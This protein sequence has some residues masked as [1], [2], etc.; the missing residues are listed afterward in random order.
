MK[1]VSKNNIPKRSRK[2]LF[3]PVL[4]LLFFLVNV[5]ASF[6]VVNS[7]FDKANEFYKEKDFQHAILLYKKL[8]SSGTESPEVYFNLGN[9]YFKCDSNAL[10]ILNYE[11]AKKLAPG[12]EDI[13]FNLNIAN[14]RNS[15]KFESA[16]ELF[17]NSWWAE[18]K[19]SKTMDGWAWLCIS[20]WLLSFLLLATFISFKASTTKRLGFWGGLFFLILAVFSFFLAEDQSNASSKKADAIVMVGA[21]NVKSSPEEKGKDIFIIHSG[22]KLRVINKEGAWSEIQLPDKNVGWLPTSSIDFI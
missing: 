12:D 5:W 21:V 16:P 14:Q 8:I 19:R 13:L 4:V 9:C 7:D 2:M 15:D 17:I 1:M 20:C 6:A 22:S 10:A 3:A 18:F 11:K